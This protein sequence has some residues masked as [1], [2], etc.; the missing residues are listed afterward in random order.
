MVR[1]LGWRRPIAATARAPY[2][3][4]SQ[5]RYISTLSRHIESRLAIPPAKLA[6]SDHAPVRLGACSRNASGRLCWHKRNPCSVAL[7]FEM[8]RASP[9]HFDIANWR[10]PRRTRPLQT[11]FLNSQMN[12]IRGFSA[13]LNGVRRGH[14]VVRPSGPYHLRSRRIQHQMAASMIG[15]GLAYALTRGFVFWLKR[16]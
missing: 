6:F 9:A 13:R 15:I 2:A 10:S 16:K 8:P 5:H 7:G 14:G 4:S 1:G 11:C 3:D 12:A